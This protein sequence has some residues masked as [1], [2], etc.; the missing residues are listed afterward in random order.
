[1]TIYHVRFTCAPDYNARRLPFRPAH[2]AQLARLRELTRVVAGGPEPDGTAA[3]I[4]YRVADKADLDR[5][6]ADNVFNRA[7]LFSAWHAR[8]FVQFL[9]PSDVVA[10]DAGLKAV[11]VEGPVAEPAAVMAGLVALQRQSRIAF[12]GVL[13]NG[14]VLAVVRS[15]QPDEAATWVR[16][17]GGWEPAQLR[18]RPWSQTL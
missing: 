3:H 4:F 8:A 5:V 1:M 17:A 16:D 13:E 14:V 9:E 6:L 11:I 15:A 2:L 10:V 7:G 12:G 18:A